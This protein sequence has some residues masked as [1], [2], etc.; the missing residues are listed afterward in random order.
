LR[1][2]INQTPRLSICPAYEKSFRLVIDP[3][4]SPVFGY[5]P[6]SNQDG[7]FD[8]HSELGNLM[9]QSP[10]IVLTAQACTKTNPVNLA[11][12]EVSLL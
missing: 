3:L 5:V 6:V 4:D 12:S 10:Y 7:K 11:Q 8:I 2:G 9:M 1:E